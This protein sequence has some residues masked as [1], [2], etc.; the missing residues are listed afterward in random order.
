[1]RIIL[2][3]GKGGVGKTSV[4]SATGLL[5]AKQG[6]RTLVMSLD[7]AH[8]LSDA[9]DL[10]QELMDK[11]RGLPNQ[12]DENLWIQELDIQEEIERHWSDIFG[13]LSDILAKTGLDDVVAEELAIIPGMEEISSLLYINQYIKE[14]EFDVILLDCAPTGESIR[15]ISVPSML[16]WYMR[17]I[18]KLQRRLV[19]VA[20]PIAKTLYSVPLPADDYYASLEDLFEKMRG[21]DKVLAD[22]KITSVRLVTNPEKIVIKETQ[23]AYMYFSL[24]GLSVDAVIINRILPEGLSEEYLGEWK[25]IQENYVARIVEIFNPLPTFNVPLFPREV[26]GPEDLLKLGEALYDERD[27]L[28]VYYSDLVYRIVKENGQYVLKVTMPFVGKQDVD[29]LKRGDEL[30][31]KV[32]GYKQHIMLPKRVASNEPSRAVMVD[33]KLNIYFGGDHERQGQEGEKEGG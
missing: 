14:D 24:Y 3:T 12:V 18:F 5:A 16:D 13:Y 19:K 28:K 6:L 31:I 20:R 7:A 30:I 22:P 27:P 8:S 1:M 4:A 17:K 9:F 23:R 26:V 29:L 11:N 10:D 21:I 25:R 33:H 15:F 32:G 2:F